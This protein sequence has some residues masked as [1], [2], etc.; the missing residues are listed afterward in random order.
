MVDE[1]K[2]FTLPELMFSMLALAILTMT[3]GVVLVHG[4]RGWRANNEAVEM[5]RDISLALRVISREIRC[6][7]YTNMTHSARRIDFAAGG[8]RTNAEA[9][10]LTDFGSLI[11]HDG[12]D[13]LALVASGVSGFS[14]TG[15]ETNRGVDVV[16]DYVSDSGYDSG[17]TAFTVYARNDR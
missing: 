6:S 2:G 9:I 5:Q 13:D 1:K 17:S 8:V 4:W 11:Y 14:T 10:Y 12:H 15:D 3:A 7:K 16:L